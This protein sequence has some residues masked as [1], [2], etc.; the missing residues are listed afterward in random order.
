MNTPKKGD[1]IEYTIPQGQHY[2]KQNTF[3][4]VEYDE[5]KFTVRFDSS[6]V[7]QTTDPKNQEDI[8]KLYGFSDN[9]AEHQQFSARLGWNWARNA[10]RLYAYVYNNGERASQEITSIQIGSTCTCSIKISAHHYIFS[11]NN[12]TVDMARSSTTSNAVGYK[13]FPYF[14]GDEIAPH[15]IDIW[16]KEL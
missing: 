3:Q 12:A 10:L 16:I 8:N 9:N 5:L 4:S 15:E 14:G 7:Y 6:A 13:L 1:L 2:A 11:A